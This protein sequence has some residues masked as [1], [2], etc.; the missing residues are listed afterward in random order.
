MVGPNG[1]ID[2]HR[3]NKYESGKNLARKTKTKVNGYLGGRCR[4]PLSLNLAMSSVSR[5]QASEKDYFA[6]T[7]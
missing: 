7:A 4:Y 1:D 6:N 3:L 2:D 5:F